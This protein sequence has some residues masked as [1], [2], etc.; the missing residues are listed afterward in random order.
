MHAR[1]FT[2]A[3][4]LALLILGVLSD[5]L[6][7]QAHDRFTAAQRYEDVYYLPPREWL[8]VLSLGHDEALADLIW[9][10]ALV[11]FGEEFE[12]AGH[13][14]YVFDYAEAIEA[15]DPRFL[16]VY[17]WLG[18]AGLYRPQAITPED[19][20]RSV[21]FMQ[22]GARRFPDDGQLAWDIGAALVFELPPLLDDDAAIRRARGRGAPYLMRAVRLGAAPEWAALTNATVLAQ[23]GRREQAARHLEEMYLATDDP[24]VR[25]QIG[26]RIRSLRER[27]DAEAF[28]ATMRELEERRARDFPY[29]GPGMYVLL[30]ERP[31]AE[32]DPIREG[33]ARALARSESASDGEPDAEPE[34]APPP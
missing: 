14:R 18:M 22:R 10:R 16:A 17:R 11:Y 1:T 31:R 32:I 34:P 4:V 30:G 25:E 26:S 5:Q 9:I 33:W 6:R 2:L 12:H 24:N 7:M 13:V 29:V 21:A 27:A 20:E 19:V 23:L 28:L 3:A 15:L 8:P